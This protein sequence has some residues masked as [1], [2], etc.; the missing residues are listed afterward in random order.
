MLYSNFANKPTLTMDSMFE[1]KKSK[2]LYYVTSYFSLLSSLIAVGNAAYN[3]ILS[4]PLKMT[5]TMLIDIERFAI[6]GIIILLIS[7]EFL[8]KKPHFL[9]VLISKRQ[10]AEEPKEK[11]N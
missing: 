6:S 1:D 2:R 4:I 3:I 7:V 5:L 10:K 11:Y 9:Q 8:L